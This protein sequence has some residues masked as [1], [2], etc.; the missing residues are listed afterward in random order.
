MGGAMATAGGKQTPRLR[1]GASNQLDGEVY[2]AFT[3]AQ[4]GPRV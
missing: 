1:K 3:I 4:R 2:I